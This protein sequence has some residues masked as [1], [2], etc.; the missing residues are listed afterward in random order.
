MY[1]HLLVVQNDIRKPNPGRVNIDTFYPAIVFRIPFQMTVVPFLKIQQ[2]NKAHQS[3]L[4]MALLPQ[5][6]ISYDLPYN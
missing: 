6:T 4:K 3:A 5:L 1:N 2:M